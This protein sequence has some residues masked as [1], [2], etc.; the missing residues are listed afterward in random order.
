MNIEARSKMVFDRAAPTGYG[1]NMISSSTI[2]V[3][4]MDNATTTTV[5]T[6]AVR[7]TMGTCNAARTYRH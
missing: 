3:T 4:A 2:A 1:C 7:L 6:W 5:R